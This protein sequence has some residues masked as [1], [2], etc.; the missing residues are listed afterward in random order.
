MISSLPHLFVLLAFSVSIVVA[1]PSLCVRFYLRIHKF[2][3]H[4]TV[5]VLL[6]LIQCYLKRYDI[7]CSLV[8]SIELFVI[9]VLIYIT[10]LWLNCL[11]IYSYFVH[12]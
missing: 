9:L 1:N 3:L 12:T 11:R 8:S 6:I 4:N 10:V 5:Y 7:F 2:S